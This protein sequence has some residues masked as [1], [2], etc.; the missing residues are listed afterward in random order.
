MSRVESTT[1]V[2]VDFVMLPNRDSQSPAKQISVVGGFG[3]GQDR[4]GRVA[5]VFENSRKI[6]HSTFRRRKPSPQGT[7]QASQSSTMKLRKKIKQKRW[8]LDF[9]FWN[10]H[11]FSA[12]FYFMQNKPGLV[13]DCTNSQPIIFQN[14]YY[15]YI[16]EWYVETIWFGS[17][18]LLL[19]L[20]EVHKLSEFVK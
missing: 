13:T 7:L 10:F 18:Y 16:C 9:L 4:S 19:S 14:R 17:C 20:F 6:L 1:F 15:W 11:F 5:T 8:K 2:F 3:P 12:N